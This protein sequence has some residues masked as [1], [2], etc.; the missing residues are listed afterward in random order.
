M[1]VEGTQGFLMELT[2]ALILLS[3]VLGTIE[4]R[5]RHG[6]RS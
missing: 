4:H 6:G 2:I 3:L 1:D 5:K